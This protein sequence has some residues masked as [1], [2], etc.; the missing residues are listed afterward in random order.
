MTKRKD[1]KRE[2]Q[3]A[4]RQAVE[5]I[6]REMLEESEAHDREFDRALEEWAHHD[7]DERR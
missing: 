7:E 4:K 5:R 2:A 6:D 3:E 1:E